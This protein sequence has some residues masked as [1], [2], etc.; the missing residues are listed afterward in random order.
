MVNNFTSQSTSYELSV[1]PEPEELVL[2]LESAAGVY[3]CIWEAVRDSKTADTLYPLIGS[4]IVIQEMIT[5]LN[6]NFER[7]DGQDWYNILTGRA[8]SILE[9]KEK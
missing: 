1:D 9:E 3:A 4:V 2:C 7:Q 8:I 6:K 5:N